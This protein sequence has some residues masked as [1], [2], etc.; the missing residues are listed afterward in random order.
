MPLWVRAL[1]FTLLAPG[2]VAVLVPWWLVAHAG[3]VPLLA[4]R[5]SLGPGHAAGWLL[6]V[7]G[8]LGYLRCVLAFV[9][10]GGGT[11]F[12]PDAPR[13]FVASG[14]YRHVRNPMYVSIGAVLLGET[15]TSG[16]PVLL[17]WLGALWLLFH[18]FVVLYE[19]PH[20]GRLF[21]REYERYRANVPRWV[22][23]V[24]PW[25]ADGPPGSV[26]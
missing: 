11:P 15:V 21:G 14:L 8:A 26:T 18:A 24:T 17:V 25:E 22:P 1:I 10:E 12:P 5:W 23:R 4:V 2:T 9:R 7:P 3:G 13:R 19:E 16:A 20:L 6:V